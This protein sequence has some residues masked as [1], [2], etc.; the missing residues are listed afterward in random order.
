MTDNSLVIIGAGLAGLSTG[1][2]AQ[3]NSYRSHIFEHHAVPGGVAA[4]WKRGG[5]LIDGGIHFIIGHKPDGQ[6]AWPVADYVQAIHHPWLR[7]CAQYLFAK[8]GRRPSVARPQ[9]PPRRNR[10]RRGSM[11][12]IEPH[13]GV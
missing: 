9:L 11:V 2:Y 8:D 4:A 13:R 12:A 5:Y 10:E 7:A 1:C 3:M 6:F